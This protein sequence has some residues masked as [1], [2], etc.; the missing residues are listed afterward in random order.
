[1]R[2]D[3]FSPAPQS[4]AEALRALPQ[5]TPTRSEWSRLA[6]TIARRRAERARRWRW[7]G[8]A[9]AA[10]LAL[11]LGVS[12]LR[13][14]PPD[15]APG[16]F[17]NVEETSDAKVQRLIAENQAWERA[18]RRVDARPGAFS[19]RAAM[20]S[21]ELEDLI[22][23]VDLQISANTDINARA[24]LWSQRLTLIEQLASVRDEGLGDAVSLADSAVLPANYLID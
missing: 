6:D 4:L 2:E 20:A 18:L 9:A 16:T 12:L 21:A 5:P 22:A 13:A 3:E 23:M 1:M 10:M 8:V 19:G 7:T 15:T 24:D 17:A 11:G 14:P